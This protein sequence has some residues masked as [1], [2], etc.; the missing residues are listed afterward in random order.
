MNIELWE[1]W[2]RQADEDDA[3]R[4]TPISAWIPLGGFECESPIE[5]QLLTH[6][7]RHA[8]RW[9]FQVI[10]QFK[11]NKYRFDFA[12]EKD[13]K[14]VAVIECDGVEFHSNPEQL[15]RDAAKDKF[16]DEHG[17]EMFRFRGTDIWHRAGSCAQKVIFDL[18]SHR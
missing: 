10:I 13:N 9:G 18:W 1:N 5:R 2:Q 6:L 15:A 3:R 4:Q 17:W 8:E 7:R 16:A 12:I 11:V 14:I